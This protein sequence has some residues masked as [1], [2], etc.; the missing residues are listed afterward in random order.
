MFLSSQER[1][2]FLEKSVVHFIVCLQAVNL[3]I[4]NSECFVYICLPPTP[5]IC[6]SICVPSVKWIFTANMM[7]IN[8][9]RIV[10]SRNKIYLNTQQPLPER[11]CTVIARAWFGGICLV[12]RVLAQ[13]LPGPGVGLGAHRE[14]LWDPA[15]DRR[16]SNKQTQAFENVVVATEHRRTAEEDPEKRH[17]VAATP[18]YTRV[19]GGIDGAVCLEL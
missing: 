11:G 7:S 9:H 12:A 19:R 17:L 13:I 15:H 8:G 10:S 18:K 4:E 3:F 6:V 2:A 5:P 16:T 14:A 1:N